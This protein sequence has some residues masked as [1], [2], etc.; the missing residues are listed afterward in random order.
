MD[1]PLSE[2]LSCGFESVYQLAIKQTNDA[3]NRALEKDENG[4]YPPE[5]RVSKISAAGRV[6]LEFTNP[7]N[8]PNVEEFNSLN[9]QDSRMLSDQSKLIDLTVY[10]G[11]ELVPYDNLE[12]WNIV[13]IYQ[14]F[15][16]ID[17]IFKR[18]LYVSQGEYHDILLIQMAL[19]EYQD[20]NANSLPVTVN[21]VRNIPR[22]FKSPEDANNID[23][24][25]GAMHFSS[26]GTCACT[27]II[28]IFL[29]ASLSQ[30]WSMLNN[31]QIMV[32]M[33]MFEG[34]K[35]PAN[36]MQVVSYLIKLATFNLI[37]T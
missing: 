2:K 19:S 18:P 23:A 1:V 24:I 11:D 28:S 31:Q 12:S 34:V 17:L 13:S 4:H 30:L 8:L 16:E 15:I 5:V 3:M 14:R 33:P 20:Q 27:F 37:P 26:T 6:K 22:Q 29:S 25:G 7:L 32:H 21:R 9:F 36:S 35:F 10:D